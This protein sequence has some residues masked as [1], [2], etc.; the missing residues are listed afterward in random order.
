MNINF[1]WKKKTLQFQT[2]E[3]LYLN[4]ICVAGYS[5][6]STR[7]Q[8]DKNP[9]IDYSGNIELPS[10]NNSSVYA[11]TPE[12]IKSK[13]EKIVTAWFNEAAK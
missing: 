8:G 4:H 5:W 6:N 10:L 13:I 2:G 12:L 3:S 7:S 9:D 11:A 1:T